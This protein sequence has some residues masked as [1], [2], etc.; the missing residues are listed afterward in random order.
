MENSLQI[1]RGYTD[2]FTVQ[3]ERQRPVNRTIGH[4]QKNIAFCD[5]QVESCQIVGLSEEARG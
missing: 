1:I 3:R 5:A 2:I 4:S